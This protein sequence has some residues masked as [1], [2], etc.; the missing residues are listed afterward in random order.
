[1]HERYPMTEQLWLEWLQDEI[2]AADSV[3]S[4]DHIDKLFKNAVQ[5]YLSIPVWKAYIE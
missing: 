4:T 1:M 2:A 5:D 3:A